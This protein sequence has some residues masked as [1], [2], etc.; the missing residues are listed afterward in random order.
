MRRSPLVVASLVAIVGVHGV[1]ARIAAGQPSDAGSPPRPALSESLSGGAKEAYEAA[2][3][4]VNNKDCAHAIAKYRQA[5]DLSKDPRLLFDIALCHRDLRAYAQMQGLLQRY[6]EEAAAEMSAEQRAD[7]EAALKA[8]HDLVGTVDVTVSEA[9]ADVTVDA[10]PVGRTPLAAPIVVDL[11]KH[12][13]A[14]N[15]E[16]FE[17]AS[18]TIEIPGGNETSLSF[19]LVRQAH[20]AALRIATDP[21]ATVVIDKRE[22]GRG[23][24]D[25]ALPPGAHEVQVTAPGKKDYEARIVLGDGEARTFHV[26]LE[27]ERH[28]ALW[29]WIAGGAAVL[30][31]AG[32]GGYFLL[33]PHDTRGAG[34]QGQLFTY[35]LPPGAN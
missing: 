4:L 1:G 14:V 17:P 16:G 26:T 29:P 12:T 15:K 30:A 35:Q 8:T 31:G 24:F 33:R 10:E 6:K 25:G 22:L 9:D 27:G 21:E 2:T 19:T 28:T 3:V 32:I 11:G 23:G 5:Y 34:P 13:V 7:V 20:L 18:Q